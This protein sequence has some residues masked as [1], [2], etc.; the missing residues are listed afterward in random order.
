MAKIE[1]IQA[2]IDAH[3]KQKIKAVAQKRGFQNVSAYFRYLILRDIEE[4]SSE[5]HKK[6]EQTEIPE[7]ILRAVDLLEQAS[8]EDVR[9]LSPAEQRLYE[10]WFGKRKKDNR[11]SFVL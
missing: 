10:R 8:P 11:D 2:R 4:A 1:L 6:E 7:H 9:L 5:S 3:E